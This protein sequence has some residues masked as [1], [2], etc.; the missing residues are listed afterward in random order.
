MNL[1]I[2]LGNTAA[3]WALFEGKNLI[4]KG[5]FQ[6]SDCNEVIEMWRSKG[7][8]NVAIASVIEIPEAITNFFGS[9]NSV[10]KINQHIQ[11]PIKNAYKSPETLGVDRLVNAVAACELFQNA[12]V[13]V[14]DCGTCLKIDFTSDKEGFIG[15]AIAPGLQMRYKSLNNYTAKLPLLN[16]VFFNELTGKNTD[17]SIHNGVI[18]GMAYEIMGSI[19]N[20]SSFYSDFKIIITGGDYHYFQDVIEKKT[21]F[22]EPDL[23][24]IGINILLLL[25]ITNE[26]AH[27]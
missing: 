11:F 13:L 2:D 25:N 5:K 10:L 12:D 7:V 1:A 24:L 22:A 14:I 4:F 16:P 17:E 9:C 3:K 15:G 21:I 27:N 8:V 6:F 18:H 20:Y 26:K 19:E 23:T